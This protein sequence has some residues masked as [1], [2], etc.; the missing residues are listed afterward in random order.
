MTVLPYMGFL[1]PALL[2]DLACILAHMS[3]YENPFS[4]ITWDSSAFSSFL[5]EIS[6]LV[7]LVAY[8]LPERSLCQDT[9][10]LFRSYRDCG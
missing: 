4:G 1:L 6:L 2:P 8:L 3:N 10:D 7:S 9:K 5:I